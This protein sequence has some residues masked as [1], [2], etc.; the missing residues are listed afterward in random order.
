MEME[1]HNKQAFLPHYSK[2][3]EIKSVSKRKKWRKARNT[4][5]LLLLAKLHYFK[6]GIKVITNNP[7]CLLG[8]VY[9]G[10]KYPS[11][12]TNSAVNNANG[13]LKKGRKGERK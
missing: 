7:R 5:T 8:R 9:N 10:R 6:I 1:R 3:P 12:S 4:T 11:H 13:S 2:E